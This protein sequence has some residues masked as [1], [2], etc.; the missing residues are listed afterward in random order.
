MFRKIFKI[1][2]LKIIYEKLYLKNKNVFNI[3]LLKIIFTN[4]NNK[5]AFD[6]I[7]YL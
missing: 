6:I 4:E 7:L 3:V 5:K 2:F 1:I